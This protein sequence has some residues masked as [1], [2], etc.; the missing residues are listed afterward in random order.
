MLAFTGG[1]HPVNSEGGKG[2]CVTLGLVPRS[3]VILIYS[4]RYSRFLPSV[5]NKIRIQ[6]YYGEI[7][8]IKQNV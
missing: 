8:H 1:S 7:I 2:E 3:L 5:I 4:R 6:T